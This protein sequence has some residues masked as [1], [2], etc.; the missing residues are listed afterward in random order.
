MSTPNAIRLD[1]IESN[2]IRLENHYDGDCDLFD[3]KIQM[4]YIDY[5]L[6]DIIRKQNAVIVDL[7][8]RLSRMEVFTGMVAPAPLPIDDSMSMHFV[9]GEVDYIEPGALID[10]DMDE[11][12]Y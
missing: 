3:D 10:N 8:A 4:N 12:P 2:I 7:E 5:D 9:N 11:L 1:T 6:L